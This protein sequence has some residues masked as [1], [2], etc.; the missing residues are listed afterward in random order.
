MAADRYWVLEG[1]GATEGELTS[2]RWER[3]EWREQ[4]PELA[5]RLDTEHVGAVEPNPNYGAWTFQP[6]GEVVESRYYVCS[7]PGGSLPEWL[8]KMAATKTLPGTM[9]DAVAEARRRAGK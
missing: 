4:Y 8:Q 1:W 3:F 9:G 5:K 6:K 2:Y 7:N